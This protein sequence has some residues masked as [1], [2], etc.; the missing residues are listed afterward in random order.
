MYKYKKK[1][2]SITSIC[3]ILLVSI[4]SLGVTKSTD[5]EKKKISKNIYIEALNTGG[6]TKEECRSEIL[7]NYKVKPIIISY[8]EKSW[9]LKPED[10]DLYYDV[11]EAIDNAF[12]F[13]RSENNMENIKRIFNLNFKE[14]HVINLETNYNE[15]KLS[16]IVRNIIKE[17]NV[18]VTD[19]TIE[20]KD[21]GE[22]IRTESNEGLEVDIIKLK[23]CIYDMITSH[24]IEEIDLPVKIIKPRVTTEDIKSINTVLGQFSTSYNE[25]SARGSNISVAAKSTSDKILMPQEIFSYNNTTG[26][27]SWSNGYRTAKVIVGGKFVNGEGG[28]VCQ[29]STTIYN[30]A[31]LSGMQIEEV[32]NHTIQSHYAPRGRDAAVSYGYTD[33][34]FKNGYAHPIYIKNIVNNGAI[35]TKIY[36]CNQDREKLYIKTEENFSKDKIKVKTFRIYLDEE[37]NKIREELIADSIYKIH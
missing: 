2:K 29:V 19:A 34:K 31:L 33:L 32:H 30:A 4:T 22:I 7:K 28:G 20:I 3:C 26:Y 25:H 10:I 5:I 24:K 17:I 8:K 11:D 15:V 36:G 13:T 27:R 37:N 21:S 14:E 18:K 23:E 9:T 35:T 16:E 12:K 6:M 1:L